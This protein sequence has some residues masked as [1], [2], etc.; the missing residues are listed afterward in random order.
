MRASGVLSALVVFV[1]DWE[2]YVSPLVL[3]EIERTPKVAREKIARELR[4][5]YLLV[6]AE[7]AESLW[8]AALYIS[9]G[10]IPARYEDDARHVTV[11]AISDIGVIVSW[12]SRHV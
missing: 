6:L 10:A 4:K 1:G 5:G 3:E 11:A 2:G 9:A 12:N 8:L 7:S